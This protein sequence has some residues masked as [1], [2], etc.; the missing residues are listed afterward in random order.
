MSALAPVRHPSPRV[1]LLVGAAFLVGL[2]AQLSA[3][4]AA[5]LTGTAPGQGASEFKQLV[6]TL[7]S[8]AVWLIATGLALAFT[9]VAGLLIIGSQ[10]A[11]DHV[12]RMAG[13]IAVILVVIPAILA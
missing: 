5:G 3:L 1:I 7:Q 12:F 6:A 2:V 9:L 10:R 8:N 13:G 11:P 4:K